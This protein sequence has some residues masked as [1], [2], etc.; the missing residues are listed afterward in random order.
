M[1]LRQITCPNCSSPAGVDDTTCSYCYAAI[2][3]AGG[4]ASTNM[5]AATAAAFALGLVAADWYFG[6][7]LT[8][9]LANA[10][11]A[12]DQG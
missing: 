1:E 7:G 11:E 8:Q 5:L 12:G 10:W 2:P 4:T 3:S 6:F 9:W